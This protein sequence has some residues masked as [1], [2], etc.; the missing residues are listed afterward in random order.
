VDIQNKRRLVRAIEIASHSPRDAVTSSQSDQHF[1]LK[2]IGLT[3]ER[4]ALYAKV[5][6]RIDQMFAEGL[7]E[8]TKNLL[9]VYDRNLPAM[10]S[11]G[12]AES[13]AYLAGDI[14]LDEAIQKV[15]WRTHAYI[16]RQYTWF[17][18]Q[19]VRW[20]DVGCTNWQKEAYELAESTLS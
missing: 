1:E 2:M 15:K 12:Y 19:P 18:K 10:S 3:L 7:V 9:G 6:R 4:K 20:I 17:R 14:S 16:R 11:I 8:E 13:S 5:D